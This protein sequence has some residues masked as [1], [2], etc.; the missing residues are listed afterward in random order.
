[1]LNYTANADENLKQL[2]NHTVTVGNPYANPRSWYEV[3]INCNDVLKNFDIMRNEKKMKEAEYQQRY[4]DILCLRSFLYLQ[5]GIHFGSVPYV[6]D[7]LENVDD[8]KDASKF[9]KL[10]FTVLLDSLINVTERLTY[11]DEY[12]TGTSLNITVDGYPTTKWFVNKKFLLGDLNLWKGNYDKAATWYRQV[13]ETGTVGVIN[14]SYY[15]MYKLGWDSNGDI[16]HYITY[17]RGGDAT[18]LVTNTQWRIM[19]EQAMNTEG[20]RRE[21]VWALPFDNKFE[22]ENP[23]V[24]LF[25]PVGGKYLVKPSQQALDMWDNE[26]Q[27]AVTSA[28]TI[29]GM[30][31]DA[32][33][34]LT[35]KNIG[36]KPVVMKYLYNYLNYNTNVAVNPLQKN[37]KWFL[38]RQTHLQMRFAE[39]ANRNGRYKLA[40]AFFNN[41]I[42]A[43]YPA[44]GTDVTNYMNTLNDAYPYNFDARVSPA[45]SGPY[46]RS[47]WY[48]NIGVRAR[49]NLINM[50]VTNPSDSL[51]QIETG[52]INETG[53]EDAFEGT[54]WPDLVRV[55][56]RRND[57]AFLADKIYNKLK[58]DGDPMADIT[59]AKLMNKENWYLPFN[60]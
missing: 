8:I 36:G 59:R 11:I 19:F 6:T 55:A 15:S 38:Y 18:T 10:P 52:L 50:P 14:G 53:L 51:I 49:A 24:K 47:D 60:W 54:R 42:S 30:P 48:R 32:R 39:A 1:M 35:W 20:F 37:G 43:A 45:S 12:P 56:L 16:D 2:S 23:F 28:P 57:P 34:L 25:S 3:I 7:A 13:M 26:Q 40:W 29:P 17:S 44:V 5:L 33:G 46:Y 9:P 31:Y 27:R 22:P 4:S 41:G 58:K 21:W